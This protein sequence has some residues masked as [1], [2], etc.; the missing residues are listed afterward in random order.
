MNFYL[1]IFHGRYCN[2]ID[3]FELGILNLIKEESNN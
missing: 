2:G 1:F 3:N